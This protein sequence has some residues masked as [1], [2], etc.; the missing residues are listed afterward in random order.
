MKRMIS[1]MNRYMRWGC[2][3]LFLLLL[4]RKVVT[5]IDLTLEFLPIQ[6]DDFTCCRLS[7]RFGRNSCPRLWLFL[8]MVQ[9]RVATRTIAL[10]EFGWSGTGP[11]IRITFSFSH[12]IFWGDETVGSGM[13]ETIRSHEFTSCAWVCVERRDVSS[14]SR[15]RRE[16]R[17]RD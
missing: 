12:D 3:F 5:H 13:N 15:F 9:L 10:W 14:R 2:K 6:Q 1:Y 17:G 8:E 11:L 4:K 7:V 16:K